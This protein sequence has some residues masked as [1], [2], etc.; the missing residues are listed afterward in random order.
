MEAVARVADELG[1]LREVRVARERAESGGHAVLLLGVGRQ[2]AE[3]V[4]QRLG[5]HGPR[6]GVGERHG[7]DEDLGCVSRGQP[8]VREVAEVVGGEAGSAVSSAAC[9]SSW[10]R[11]TISGFGRSRSIRDQCHGTRRAVGLDQR[12]V[13]V[14]VALELVQRPATRADPSDVRAAGQQR[15]PLVLGRLPQRAERERGRRASL[16]AART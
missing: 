3:P 4:E 12:V 7:D 16:A 1:D 14:G 8:L 9:F 5:G 15:R 13:A 10:R 6:L 2:L 11:P